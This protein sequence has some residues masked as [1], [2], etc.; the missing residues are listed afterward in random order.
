MSVKEFSFQDRPLHFALVEAAGPQLAIPSCASRF[1]YVVEEP[2]GSEC[3][4]LN[5]GHVPD[6]ALHGEKAARTLRFPLDPLPISIAPHQNGQLVFL[7]PSA[8][9]APSDSDPDDPIWLGYCDVS[10]MCTI[11]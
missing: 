5:C 2:T 9:T 1:A 4:R 10:A 6:L 3:Q 7:F 8:Q 11:N